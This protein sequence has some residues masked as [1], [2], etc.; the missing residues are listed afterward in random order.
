MIL[1]GDIIEAIYADR[2]AIDVDTVITFQDGT[3]QRIRTRLDVVDLAAAPAPAA[4]DEA[5]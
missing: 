4:R 2:P 1:V 3:R 5:A